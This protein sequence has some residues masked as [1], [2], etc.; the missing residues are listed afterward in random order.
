MTDKDNVAEWI[1]QR[2]DVMPRINPRI[3]DADR[4]IAGSRSRY[5]DLTDIGGR[6]SPRNLKEFEALSDQQQNQYLMSS[7]KYMRRTMGK[8]LLLFVP[9]KALFI[10]RR[11]Y[12]QPFRLGRC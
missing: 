7:M 5:L 11:A 3:L 12:P 1:M 6:Y 2:A 4:D 8:E 10:L 9:I